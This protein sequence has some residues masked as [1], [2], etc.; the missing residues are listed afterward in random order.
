VQYLH[1][2]LPV[3]AAA[4]KTD[5]LKFSFDT[6]WEHEKVKIIPPDLIFSIAF[7]FN[8]LYPWRA[9]ARTLLCLAKAGGSRMIR[10]YLSLYHS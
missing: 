6:T 10:S 4:A 7:I 1:F 9:F 2:S 3:F 5:F 8:L